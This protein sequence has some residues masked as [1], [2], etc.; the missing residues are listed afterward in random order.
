[1]N[2][3]QRR[4]GRQPDSLLSPSP[5]AEPGGLRATMREHLEWMAVRHYAQGSL[6]GRADALRW[7]AEWCE[8]RSLSRPEEVTKPILER[9]QRHLFL[10]RKANGKPLGVGTQAGRLL[11]LKGYFKWLTRQNFLP[12]NPASELELPR[13]PKGLPRYVLTA[14]EAD[15]VL[16]QPDLSTPAGV[17]DRA[18]LEV[19]YSTGMRRAE[20]AEL[21][22]FSIRAEQGVVTIY[23]GKG[24]KDRVVP[25]GERAVAWV[26]K[27]VEEVRPGLVVPPDEGVLFLTEL[28]E[29]FNLNRL[30][31]VVREYVQASG[32][33]KRGA[34]HLFRH[35]MA[36]LM[37]ENGADVRFV[38]EMLGHA[39][40]E[41]TQ[42]YTRVSI[43]KLKEIHAAT[44]PSAKLERK[45][46]LP[47]E[48]AEVE[49]DEREALLSSLAAESVEDDEE[50]SEP[51]GSE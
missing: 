18:I 27:Y 3:W 23:E 44:H 36:T 49:L 2:R 6:N 38:Q 7:F 37:L 42:I 22:V 24:K 25:I 48:S 21:T 47:S 30:T 5:T 45:S 33:A 8:E 10:Y 51:E 20:L 9:Y 41:S 16:A 39:S 17:R 26:E 32:V 35:A 31:T 34:C 28:G 15:T 14:N 43:R 13:R 4:R 29:R 19:L 11:G 12:S 40:L 50:P 46:E 1:M